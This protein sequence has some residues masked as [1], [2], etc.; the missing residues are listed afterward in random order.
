MYSYL[1]M[2]LHEM[3][4]LIFPSLFVRIVMLIILEVVRNF[5][6]CFGQVSTS[7]KCSSIFPHAY[8]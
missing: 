6:G 5:S 2:S 4:F 1:L 3:K 8:I 7:E